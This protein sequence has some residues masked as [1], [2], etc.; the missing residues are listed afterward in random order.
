[1]VEVGPGVEGINAGDRVTAVASGAM[2]EYIVVSPAFLNFLVYKLPPEVS[3]EEAATVEPLATSLHATKLGT[4]A[5]GETVAIIGAGI[6][7]LGIVQSLKAMDLELKKIIV[8]DV[9]DFRLE[10]AKKLGATDVVNIRTTDPVERVTEIAGTLPFMFQ[11]EI[12]APAVDV[13]YDAVGFIKDNPAPPAID[14]ALSF[15]REHGRVVLVG[16]HED[17]LSVN[18]QRAVHKQLKICGSFAYLPDDI[19]EGIEYIRAGKID[20]KS[21]ITHTFPLEKAREAF[22]TQLITGESVKVVFTI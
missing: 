14:R 12:V 15:V 10:I 16:A 6:I 2:A 21:L 9:S 4:P 7:G 17:A 3:Y 22:E 8:V 11:P 19:I 5:N 20:R 18:L 1:V 13:V